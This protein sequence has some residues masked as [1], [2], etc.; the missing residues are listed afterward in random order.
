MSESLAPKLFIYRLLDV[1]GSCF[2]SRHSSITAVAI[3]TH[4]QLTQFRFSALP[5]RRLKVIKQELSSPVENCKQRVIYHTGE[6]LVRPDSAI[7]GPG[8]DKACSLLAHCHALT[9]SQKRGMQEAPA[10][11]ARLITLPVLIKW[12]HSSGELLQG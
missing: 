4:A 2:Q 5:S 12:S 9:G 8:R 10:A 1:L 7:S 6:G 3:A 11:R